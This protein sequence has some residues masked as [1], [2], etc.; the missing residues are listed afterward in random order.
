MKFKFSKRTN[1]IKPSPIRELAKLIQDS[2]IISFAG[3]MPAPELFPIEELSGIS[4]DLIKRDGKKVLQ[5]SSTEGLYELRKIIS[6]RM[7]RFNI[8]C[9][10]ENI[11]ITNGSQQ[12]LEFTGKLFIDDGDIVI[13]ENPSYIGALN[14][15]RVYNPKLVSV[16]V[17]NNGMIIE[18]LEKILRNH[19]NI[20]Y[21]Y[22][23]PS[24]QNPTGVSMSVE[25]KRRLVELSREY[26]VAIIEDNPYLEL[27]YGKN[28]EFPVKSYDKNENVIYLGSFSKTFC[29]GLRVGWIVGPEDVIRKY[30]L[31]KQGV[32]LH[33]NTLA[34]YQ[35]AE[36]IKEFDYEEHVEKIKNVYKRRRDTMLKSI[37]EEF[38]KEIKYTKPDG[39]MFI[40]VELPENIDANMIFKNALN[41]KVAFVPGNAFFAEGKV[42]NCLRLNYATMDEERIEEGIRRLGEVLRTSLNKS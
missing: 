16:P 17:D 31:I 4:R 38:P 28:I 15:F 21:I 35:I 24:F 2:E 36:F 23:V 37:E 18:E 3:G 34:Q 11:L 19:S 42:N 14:A 5:Y 26:G 33:V 27:N 1:Y 20:K 40:W 29:P 25:R 13:C 30:S 22:T 6:D 8:A 41:K 12:G 39:G 9:S 10:P 7:N 32:D